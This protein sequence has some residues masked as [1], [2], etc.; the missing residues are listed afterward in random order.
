MWYH[1]SRREESKLEMKRKGDL[2]CDNQIERAV[3]LNIKIRV[4]DT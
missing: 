2:P 3:S 1:D 4:S